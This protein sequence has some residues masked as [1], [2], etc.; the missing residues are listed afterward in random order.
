M[1]DSEDLARG[2]CWCLE[3]NQDGALSKAAREKVM[4][5]YTIENVGKKYTELYS[6][7]IEK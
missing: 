7:I 5:E 6:T 2:I 1:Q 3:N 4:R